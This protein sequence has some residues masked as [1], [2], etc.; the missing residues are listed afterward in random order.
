[1]VVDDP[2]NGE[3]KF[4]A[5]LGDV[6]ISNEHEYAKD[7]HEAIV[8]NMKH[9][10]VGRDTTLGDHHAKRTRL[11][12]VDLESEN[13]GNQIDSLPSGPAHLIAKYALP[14]SFKGYGGRSRRPSSKR[15]RQKRRHGR[16]HTFSKR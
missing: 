15:T 14:R 7:Q 10:L 4:V 8:N 13:L 16:R 5:L 9:Y 12:P 6:P 11:S 3:S 2:D 1:V